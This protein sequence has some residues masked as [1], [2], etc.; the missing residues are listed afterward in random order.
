MREFAEPADVDEATQ[1][2]DELGTAGFVVA[3]VGDGTCQSL[4]AHAGDEPTA[5]G[6]SF[7]LYVLGAVVAAV[8]AGAISWDTPVTIDDAL[9]S[10][11]SGTTQGDEPG[12]EVPVR[13]L[14]ERMISV[15]DNTATDDLIA[16][17]G[18]DAVE[19]MLPVMGNDA[20]DR[21][22]PFLTTR[23]LFIV[24]WG[25]DGLAERYAAAD[26][27]GRRTILAD[28][29][30]GAELPGVTDVDPQHPIFI[31]DIEWF[32]SPMAL[33]AAIE[34]LAADDTARAVLSINPGTPD[35]TGQWTEILFKGGSEP[36]VLAA[37]WRVEDA[38]GRAFVVA[39]GVIDPE[40]PIDEFAAVSLFEYLRNQAADAR[41]QSP[42]TSTA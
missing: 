36:G 19:A 28:E 21:N 8:E 35:T 4:V 3:E 34:W 29:V 7:K 2:L 42:A 15:S 6:S 39:G 30:A 10:L 12:T 37:V 24:K 25:P 41:A 31:D 5:L 16:V 27:S 40:S 23:E 9:D 13:E 22:L 38:E 11:P 32:A 18:R 1:R 14:A 26:E 20:V 17:V 33:C